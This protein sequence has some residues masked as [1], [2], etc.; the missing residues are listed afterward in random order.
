MAAICKYCNLDMREADGCLKMA[1][2]L[3]DGRKLDP[4]P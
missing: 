4:I 3:K 1:V 2:D